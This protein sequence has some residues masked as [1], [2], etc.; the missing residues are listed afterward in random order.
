[1]V[2][3]WSEYIYEMFTDEGGRR[4]RHEACRVSPTLQYSCTAQFLKRYRACIVCS[5]FGWQ[6]QTFECFRPQTTRHAQTIII[7][8]VCIINS[9]TRVGDKQSATEPPQ[10]VHERNFLAES[11]PLLRVHTQ[12]SRSCRLLLTH[13]DIRFHF[14]FTNFEAWHLIIT[15]SN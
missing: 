1:M 10:S 8:L 2:D 15:N 13:C 4:A 6:T 14:V 11:S 12:Q 3:S 9:E 7:V 5:T